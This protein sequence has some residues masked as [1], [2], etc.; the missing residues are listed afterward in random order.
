MMR[1]IEIRVKSVYSNVSACGSHVKTGMNSERE[2]YFCFVLSS[3][4][5]WEV[6]KLAAREARDAAHVLSR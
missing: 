5:T 6:I 4:P 2:I 3:L 1:E